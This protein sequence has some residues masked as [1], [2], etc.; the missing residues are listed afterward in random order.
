MQ[1]E[2]KLYILYNFIYN[3]CCVSVYTYTD[4][5]KGGKI[6]TLPI[7]KT[8]VFKIFRTCFSM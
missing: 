1:L 5:F 2:S 3:L 6:L 7:Q 4:K 8:W